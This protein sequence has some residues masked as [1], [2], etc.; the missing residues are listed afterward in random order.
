MSFNF[1]WPEFS[2]SFYHD[3]RAMLAQVSLHAVSCTSEL[4]ERALAG[5]QQGREAADHCR[6]D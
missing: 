5:A 3:A 2:D 6:Q 1:T 4:T